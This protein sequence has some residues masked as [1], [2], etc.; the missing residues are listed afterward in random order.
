MSDAGAEASVY[1]NREEREKLRADQV[2]L[3]YALDVITLRKAF[4]SRKV[5]DQ[6]RI[7]DFLILYG[8]T[9]SSKKIIYP[10][11]SVTTRVKLRSN[12]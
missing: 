11:R 7:S 2:F 12:A 5:N 10:G 3:N 6:A 1:C 8:P 9:M 4:I